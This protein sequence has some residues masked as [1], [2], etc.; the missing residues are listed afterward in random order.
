[1]ENA[2]A[3]VKKN[4]LAV[5]QIT[6]LDA[7]NADLRQWLDTIANVRVH[8]ATH[9]KPVELFATEKAALRPLPILP[10]DVAVIRPARANSQFRVIV[11]TNRYSVP[12]EHAGA[13]VTLK[14]YPG[15]YHE[16]LN[17]PEREQ[18]LAD[19]LAWLAAH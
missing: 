11:E 17:E 9:Q 6:I 12:A 3:N 13:P 19:I 8:G 10:Y 16:L 7:L 18:V 14:L 1:M 2:V 4:F 5:R 15:F